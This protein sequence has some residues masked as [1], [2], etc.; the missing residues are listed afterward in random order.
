ML[1]WRTLM[2]VGLLCVSACAQ[3]PFYTDNSGV[4]DRG[5]FHLEFSNELD[6]LQHS[7]FPDRW[8]NTSNYRLNFGLPHDLE[9][10]IDNPLLMIL[11][12]PVAHPPRAR[13]FGD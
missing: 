1:K 10:D 7:Q 11:R 5:K 9:I 12:D 13:G 6:R 8:Q 4:T 2:L 3:Q